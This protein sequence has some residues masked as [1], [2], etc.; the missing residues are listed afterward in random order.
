MQK[1]T[2]K[3]KKIPERQCMGCNMRFPKMELL[4]VVR[5]PDGEICLDFTGKKSGRGAYV[6]KKA[7]CLKKAQK[8]K[9]LERTLECTIPEDVFFKM[10][11]ELENVDTQRNE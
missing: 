4:R 10:E 3:Q 11:E 1:Q 7:E 8:S 5:T 6:C 2:V 9:R